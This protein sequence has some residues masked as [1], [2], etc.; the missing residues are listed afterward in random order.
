[1]VQKLLDIG[2]LRGQVEKG[3]PGLEKEGELG[4]LPIPLELLVG[5]TCLLVCLGG[6]KAGIFFHLCF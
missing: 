2:A 6:P 1:M 5:P 3:C 4:L